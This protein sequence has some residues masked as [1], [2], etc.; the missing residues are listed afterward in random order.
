MAVKPLDPEIIAKLI[1]G[2]K[3]ILTGAK[4]ERNAFYASQSCPVC[5]GNAFSKIGD[6]RTVFRPTDP[7]ARF[8]LK[9]DNCDCLFD[10]HSGVQ[11]TLGN[12]GKA[13]KKPF[14]ILND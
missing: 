3:D 12:A 8:L 14:V 10:P 9:C 5:G 6:S 1:E 13:Y 7:I 4:E 2:E 11:L